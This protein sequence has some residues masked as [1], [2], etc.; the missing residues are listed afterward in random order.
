MLMKR[1]QR[2]QA[3]EPAFFVPIFELGFVLEIIVCCIE[4]K[5]RNGARGT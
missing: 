1:V 2:H 5:Y 3:T 4:K